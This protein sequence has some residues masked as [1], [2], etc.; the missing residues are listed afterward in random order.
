MN[1][2]DLVTYLTGLM[3]RKMRNM[4]HIW[5]QFILNIIIQFGPIDWWEEKMRNMSYINLY[6]TMIIKINFSLYADSGLR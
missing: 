2:C 1:I 3:G 6:L 5:Y 4:I